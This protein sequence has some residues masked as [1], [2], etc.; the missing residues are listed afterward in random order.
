M[1][2]NFKK[3]ILFAILTEL[4]QCLKKWPFHL[5]GGGGITEMEKKPFLTLPLYFFYSNTY[6]GVDL[7]LIARKTIFFKKGIRNHNILWSV[8]L[9]FQFQDC[10]L[11]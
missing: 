10:Y 7:I 11:V 1:W 5:K 2:E 9:E 3:Y 8:H 4:G 6:F